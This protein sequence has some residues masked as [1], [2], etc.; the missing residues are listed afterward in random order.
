MEATTSSSQSGSDSAADAGHQILLFRGDKRLGASATASGLTKSGNK[1]RVRRIQVELPLLR[2]QV[3]GLELK[4][5][6]LQLQNV[7]TPAI[8][9]SRYKCTNGQIQVAQVSNLWNQVAERQLK[10]RLRVEQRQ[11]NLKESCK[12]FVLYSSELHKLFAKFEEAREETSKRL[13]GRPQYP[14]WDFAA[15]GDDEMVSEQM[16]V[17]SKLYLQVQQQFQN[18]GRTMHFG[19]ELAMG[20]D[21]PRL[22]PSVQAGIVFDAHCGVLLPFSLDVA[23][24]AYWKL[25]RFDHIEEQTSKKS[26]DDLE[27]IFSRSFTVRANFEGCTSEAQGK[28]LCK[29]YVRKDYVAVVWSGV[30]NLSEY[31]GVKFHGMQLHKRG[32]IK[33]RRV[34]RQGPGQQSTSTIVE[35]NFKTIPIFHGSVTDQTQ[36]MQAFISALNRSFSRMN[37]KFCQMMSDQLLKEDWRATF[38]REKPPM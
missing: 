23:V 37:A 10:E 6:R 15:H 27:D 7:S 5:K 2:Q 12:E 33:L 24:E 8:A 31:G 28:Y 25:F 20:R 3:Q 13:G 32:F 35:T 1:K 26:W 34:C 36:Q 9:Q 17:V 19:S 11:L 29:K 30:W 14:F 18:P 38:E 16:L 21:I 4:L 22:D